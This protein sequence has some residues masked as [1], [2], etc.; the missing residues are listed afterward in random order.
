MATLDLTLLPLYRLGKQEL[1]ALPGLLAMTPPRKTARSRE[2]DRL[3]VYLVLTGQSTFSTAEYFQLTS[4]TASRFFETPGALTTAMRAGAEALNRV[5][6]ERNL[7]SSGRGQYT[8]GWLVLAILRATT[9]T[10][11]QSGPT[12]IIQMGREGL[13]HWHDPALSGKGLG[14]SQTTTYHFSQIELQSGDRLLFSGKPPANWEQALIEDGNPASL[15]VVRRRLF[16]TAQNDLNAVLLQAKTGSGD[17]IVFRPGSPDGRPTIQAA[18]ASNSPTPVSGTESLPQHPVRDPI[19]DPAVLEPQGKNPAHWLTPAP[20]NIADA[21]E[22]PTNPAMLLNQDLLSGAE[23]P[24]AYAIPPQPIDEEYPLENNGNGMQFPASI[25]HAGEIPTTEAP[26]PLQEMDEP[27]MSEPKQPREPRQLSKAARKTALALVG[28][29][30]AGRRIGALFSRNLQKFLPNLLPGEEGAAYSPSFLMFLIAIIIPLLVVAVGSTVYLR[31]G[32]SYQYDHYYLQAQAAREQAAS[33]TDPV[34]QRDNWRL[35]LFF[36]NKADTY[37]DPTPESK[38]LRGEAQNKLDE[39]EGIQRL[40]FYP[41]LGNGVDAQISRMAANETDLF[42]LDAESGRVLRVSQVGQ[43][44]ELDHTFRCEPGIYGD[45]QVSPIVDILALPRLN[46]LDASVLGID[47]GGNLLYC[48]PGM[49][50]QAIPLPIPDTNWGRITGITLDRGNLYVLDASSRAIWVYT[51]KDAS[52]VDRPYFFFGGQIPEIEDSIDLVVS[53]DDMFLLHADGHLSTCSYSRLETAP[54]RCVDPATLIN[55][56]PA[57][58]G[59]DIFAQ[60]HFTQMQLAVPPDSSILLLDA[61]TQ[62]IFR[63]GQRSLELQTQLRPAPDSKNPLPRGPAGAMT[64]NPNGILFLAVDE[65]V[66]FASNAP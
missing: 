26:L 19:P 35:T 59:L 56:Y 45:Y 62:G 44:F 53:G 15:E 57:Y 63:I 1:P 4:Q 30:Q 28:G 41:V 5:L 55:N 64:V 50:P 48:A 31:Y 52:F 3:I 49:V 32:R 46:S 36:L 8:V 40:N 20:P 38:A 13:R 27:I 66:Y 29:I 7:A 22:P 65:R 16:S 11:L 61:D 6:L 43:E 37:R 54:T 42:L 10:L 23:A 24:S 2:N 25:S 60:A 47:A 18:Q 17:L 39:L 12:H 33:T 21:P 34:R 14:L 51:G 9:C 58:Q